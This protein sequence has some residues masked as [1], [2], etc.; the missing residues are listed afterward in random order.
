MSKRDLNNLQPYNNNGANKDDVEEGKD[1]SD[2]DITFNLRTWR[3]CSSCGTTTITTTTITITATD[4]E[5]A[6][7][8]SGKTSDEYDYFVYHFW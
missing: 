2:D 8:S 3:R 1:D 6:S 4:D 5:E 7:F